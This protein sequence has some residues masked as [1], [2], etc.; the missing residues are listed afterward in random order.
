MTPNI[1]LMN[2]ATPP[3]KNLIVAELLSCCY[4]RDLE[5][6]IDQQ[7]APDVRWLLAVLSTLNPKHRFFASDYEPP[8]QLYWSSSAEE[9]QVNLFQG[10]PKRLVQESR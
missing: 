7:N 2:C 8:A 9:M 4:T 5:T 3:K 6:G 10:L 1:R